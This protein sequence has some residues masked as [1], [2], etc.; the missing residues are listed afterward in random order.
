[1]NREGKGGGYIEKEFLL[2]KR[3]KTEKEDYIWRRIF[4]SEE[5]KK[6]N[7]E[8]IWRRKICFLQGRRLTVE[9]KVENIWR[10]N[11]CFFFAEEKNKGE[12]GSFVRGWSI[13]M[14]ICKRLV[15]SEDHLQE[16]VA[17]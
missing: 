1:M 6:K 3:N 12:G 2:L 15:R 7:E 9:M 11:I 4:F 10:R 13:W 5:N 14:I 16:V 17:S 8:H